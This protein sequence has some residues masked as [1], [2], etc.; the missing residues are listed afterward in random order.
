MTDNEMKTLRVGDHVGVQNDHET[1]DFATITDIFP[2][3]SDGKILVVFYTD[4]RYGATS[5]D[6]L[7]KLN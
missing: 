4:S 1:F 7:L 2:P 3:R 5:H 6:K